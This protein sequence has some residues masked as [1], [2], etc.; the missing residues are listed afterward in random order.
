M[1]FKFHPVDFH[2]TFQPVEV[3][4]SFIHSLISAVVPSGVQPCVYFNTWRRAWQAAYDDNGL[5]VDGAHCC[6]VPPRQGLETSSIKGQAV[7]VSN[8]AG[9]TVSAATTQLSPAFVAHEQPESTGPR[10]S[11]TAFQRD[12]CYRR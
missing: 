1:N 4:L 9:Q 7:N 3:T 2:T 12:L 5:G 10:M 11:R 6:L 8:F